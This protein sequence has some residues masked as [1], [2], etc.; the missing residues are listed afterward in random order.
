M[1]LMANEA[2]G[3]Y[4]GSLN[5]TEV[6]MKLLENPKLREEK[7]SRVV[8]SPFPFVNPEAPLEEVTQ[9]ITQENHAV[10]VKDALGETHIITRQDIVE[11]LC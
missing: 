9:L 2:D 3:N 10:L 6:F 8:Q 1:K 7:V 11:A 5:D 4:T